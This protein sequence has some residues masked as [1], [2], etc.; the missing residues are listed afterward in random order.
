MLV[1]H[2]H[3]ILKKIYESIYFLLVCCVTVSRSIYNSSITDQ[4]GLDSSP[5]HLL[6]HSPNNLPAPSLAHSPG[7]EGAG[8]LWL[9][10]FQH[11]HLFLTF[12]LHNLAPLLHT[13]LAR[14]S[15][16]PCVRLGLPYFPLHYSASLH[17]YLGT[18]FTRI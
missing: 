18:R 13:C 4:A 1:C 8:L 3:K 9:K 12:L 14:H 6:T 10:L 17:F 16:T 11:S 5:L 2:V 7:E 15:C